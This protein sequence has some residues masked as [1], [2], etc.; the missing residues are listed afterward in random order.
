MGLLGNFSD[1][2]AQLMDAAKKGGDVSSQLKAAQSAASDPFKVTGNS[3]SQPSTSTL[4]S[5]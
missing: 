2:S 1:P 3:L 4:I 5:E